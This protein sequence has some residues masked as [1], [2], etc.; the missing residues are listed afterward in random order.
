MDMV[1][2]PPDLEKFK[3]EVKVL[4]SLN[5]DIR[6]CHAYE[7]IARSYGFKSYNAYLAWLR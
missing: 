5:P 3:L 2:T 4:K 7:A 6:S 1:F